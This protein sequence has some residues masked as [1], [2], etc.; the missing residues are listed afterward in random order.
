MATAQT[1]TITPQGQVLPRIGAANPVRNHNIV[2]KPRGRALAL[3]IGAVLAVPTVS[4]LASR[5]DQLA[6]STIPDTEQNL[7][8]HEY[9]MEGIPA[10]GAFDFAA[11]VD[12]N[13]DPRNGVIRFQDQ[14]GHDP[15]P[16]DMVAVPVDAK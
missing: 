16:G 2:V 9:K 4:Y 12:P 5:F 3:F 1:Q 14:L 13:H 6:A 7:N 11:Q 8:P 15:E 10:E